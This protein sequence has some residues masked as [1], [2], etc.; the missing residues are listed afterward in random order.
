MTHSDGTAVFEKIPL[1]DTWKA[2]EK[3]VDD[4]IAKRIGVS[5]YSIEQMERIRYAPSVRI[6]P[7]CNQV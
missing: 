3:L 5:N 7:F 6:Q 4:G 1:A 2:M